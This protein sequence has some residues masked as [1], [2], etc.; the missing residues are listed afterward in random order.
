[1][2]PGETI[3]VH[4]TEDGELEI[5]PDSGF[6]PVILIEPGV[7]TDFSFESKRG[8]WGLN[9]A[10]VG[11]SLGAL[12]MLVNKL[13][14]STRVTVATDD[15]FTTFQIDASEDSVKGML[16][17]FSQSLDGAQNDIT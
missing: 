9:G 13:G 17:P 2:D 14:W 7:V 3:A 11:D 5:R 6:G 1:V 15:G 8:G 10:S 12:P 16:R 4:A